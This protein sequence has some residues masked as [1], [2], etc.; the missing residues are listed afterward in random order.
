MLEGDKASQHVFTIHL[1]KTMNRKLI[2]SEGYQGYGYL[3]SKTAVKRE[4]EENLWW[5][6]FISKSSNALKS[7]FPIFY[8]IREVITIGDA[9]Q[10]EC[11]GHKSHG[12]LPSLNPIA[13]VGTRH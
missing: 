2:G 3:H 10:D 8:K 9:L 1:D 7:K 5:N 4:S 12:S 11:T 13:R 6:A